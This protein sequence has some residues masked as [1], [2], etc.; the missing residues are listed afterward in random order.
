MDEK[1]FEKLKNDVRIWRELKINM[2]VGI[3]NVAMLIEEIEHLR[4][5][6]A[7]MWA[8]IHRGYAGDAAEMATMLVD[9]ELLD[10]AL[11]ELD[12]EDEGD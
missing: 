10:Q 7:A 4:G 3:G 11:A 6:I 8:R 5:E 12:E 1:K 2:V 9:E